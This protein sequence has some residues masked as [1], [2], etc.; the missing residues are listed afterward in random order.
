MYK[1]LLDNAGDLN[2]MAILPL[3]IFVLFFT[4][5]VVVTFVRDKKHIDHMA[6]MPLQDEPE[7]INSQS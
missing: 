4:L 3:L 7:T 6:Q 2:W 5:V 1:Y